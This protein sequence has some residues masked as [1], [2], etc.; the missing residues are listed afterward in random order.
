M[1]PRIASP[2]PLTGRRRTAC[3]S[4]VDR[5]APGCRSLCGRRAG[6]QEPDAPGVVGA[7]ELQPRGR[8]LVRLRRRR[9]AAGRRGRL[10]RRARTAVDLEVVGD[11]ARAGRR[12]PP[13]SA[14][15]SRAPSPYSARAA[16]SS[17]SDFSRGADAGELVLARCGTPAPAP[18]RSPRAAGELRLA[19]R[20]VES[21]RV[22]RLARRGAA[23]PRRRRRSCAARSRLDPADRRARRRACRA[24]RPMRA[25]GGRRRAPSRAAARSR[26]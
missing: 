10:R 17:S 24:A 25:R 7:R 16:S 13:D 4:G 18:S 20:A 12:R 2:R 9:A 8:V 22:D 5:P 23:R 21:Q 15:T 19:R 6:D 1:A 11:R 3:A 14:R 26:R